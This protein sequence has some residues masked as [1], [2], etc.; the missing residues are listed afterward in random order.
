MDDRTGSF[1]RRKISCLQHLCGDIADGRSFTRAGMDLF[2]R[3]GK[4]WERSGEEHVE[5]AHETDALSALLTQAG[6]CDIR[7]RRDG[8][9]GDAGRL[10]IIARRNENG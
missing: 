1:H 10:Y 3:R 2:S 6:F 7:L 8:P 9:Q 5:Y 4:L